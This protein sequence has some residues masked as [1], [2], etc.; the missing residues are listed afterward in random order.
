MQLGAGYSLDI[1]KDDFGFRM[2]LVQQ[3]RVCNV[4]IKYAASSDDISQLPKADYATI[5][6][7]AEDLRM[8]Y[9]YERTYYDNQVTYTIK[10]AEASFC[11]STT[12]TVRG[13]IEDDGNHYYYF[14]AKADRAVDIRFIGSD[15]GR[16]NVSSNAGI[17][18]GDINNRNGTTTLTAQIISL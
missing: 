13:T 1:H 8:K 17:V 6:P 18:A 2:G 10:T 3:F 7:S 15:E 14:D 12:C 16:I 9:R 11:I 4:K 5:S